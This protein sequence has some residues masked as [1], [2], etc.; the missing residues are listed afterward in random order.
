MSLEE[1]EIWKHMAAVKSLQPAAGEILSNHKGNE[2]GNYP[3]VTHVSPGECVFNKT[4]TVDSEGET[5]A[6]ES[7]CECCSFG[8]GY[9]HSLVF[10]NDLN[11]Q[12]SQPCKPSNLY[13]ILCDSLKF[14]SLA[15]TG[16][17][18]HG[19]WHLV[20]PML[21]GWDRY[22]RVTLRVGVCLHRCHL[23]QLAMSV[24]GGALGQAS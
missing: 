15:K 4:G 23:H 12:G 20:I 17:S 13:V 14:S 24:E 1:E 8:K 6:S 2:G 5:R 9:R 18:R 16:S 19:D 11:Q 22:L 21:T 10:W 3:A 7:H